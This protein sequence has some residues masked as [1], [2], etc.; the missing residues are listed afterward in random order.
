MMIHAEAE[1]LRRAFNK[2]R[3]SANLVTDSSQDLLLFYAVECGLKHAYLR[4]NRLNNTNKIDPEILDYK[5]DITRW[6]AELKISA[7][8]ISFKE[9]FRYRKRDGNDHIRVIHQAWRY[10]ILVN[11]D[12]EHKIVSSLRDLESWIGENW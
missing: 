11:E 12:D 8:N 3:N 10:G 4:E 6:F 5:H 7:Q 2:H 1:E 9:N